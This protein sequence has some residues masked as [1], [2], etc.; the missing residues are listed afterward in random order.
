MDGD[1]N[2][3]FY[4]GGAAG[5]SAVLYNGRNDGSIVK[6][7]SQ[8]WNQDRASEDADAL[9]FDANGD[10]HLDLYVVSGS[11]EFEE[12]SPNYQDR[13]YMNNG[14]GVFTKSNGLPTMFSSGSTI[15]AGDWDNDGDLDLFIG[16]KSI[17]GQY[18]LPGTSYLLT[19]DKGVF[20]DVTTAN[21]PEVSNCGMVNGAIATDYNGDGQIDLMVVGEWM[22][23]QCYKNESGRLIRDHSV[24][25]LENTNGWWFSIQQGDFDGDGDMDY[26][27][28]NL[29]LNYK[30]KASVTNP[31]EVWYKDFDQ[32]GK[33]D[34]VLSYYNNGKMC[35]VRGR[36]CSSQ[37]IPEITDR[38]TDYSSFAASDL[39]QI[40]GKEELESAT[41][42]QV[43]TFATTYIENLGNGRF[44]TSALPYM[45]QLSS[46]NSIIIE[47]LDNDGHLDILTAGNLYQSEVETPRNDAGKGIFLKGNGQGEF[48][49]IPN[50]KSGFWTQGDVKKLRIRKSNNGALEVMVAVNDDV[51][52]R[53]LIIP[54]SERKNK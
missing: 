11:N 1:G 37:Q 3:D 54:D 50:A 28:G 22:G 14:S 20:K 2:E 27:A 17:P 21:A 6:S 42:Y 43:Q 23:I 44:R 16:G 8:P 5:F 25:G 12:N 31:F 29:G 41:H 7:A 51:L 47:D 18:P 36:T 40:Y 49:F 9:F 33:E 26:V 10:G 32:N 24:T 19:N 39:F 45:T 34:I 53:F 35:P 15:V 38:F 46:C 30:Y 13:L 48:T 4:L 52:Q